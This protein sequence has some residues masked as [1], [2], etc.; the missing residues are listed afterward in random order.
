M[1]LHAPFTPRVGALI[2]VGAFLLGGCHDRSTAEFSDDPQGARVTVTV[3]YHSGV[4]DALNR[5]GALVRHIVRER[6][7]VRDSVVY[8]PGYVATTYHD[9][10]H[11]H[12]PATHATLLAGDEAGSD[13]CWYWPLREGTQ[14]QTVTLRPG[15]R[16]VLTLRAEGGFTGEAM[17]GSITPTTALDQRVTISL[18]ADGPQVSPIG[19]AGSPDGNN[20][21]P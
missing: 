20:A 19:V 12:Q 2:A 18:G 10:I 21:N 14:R 16:I 17:I 11:E 8:A 13:A 5:N 1:T 9:E 7:R 15:H 6:R 4:C 3:I